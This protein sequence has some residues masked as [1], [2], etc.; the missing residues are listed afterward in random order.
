MNAT[1]RHGDDAVSQSLDEL[2][3]DDDEEPLLPLLVLVPLLPLLV[4][5]LV[6]LLPLLVLVPLLPLLVLVPLLP[7]LVLPLAPSLAVA[8]PL[9]AAPSDVDFDFDDA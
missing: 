4:L 6:P 5:V 7:L 3:P 1:L 9:D 8:S 2:P